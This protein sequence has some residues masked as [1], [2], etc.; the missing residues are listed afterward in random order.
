MQSGFEIP[1]PIP[2]EVEFGDGVLTCMGALISG[3]DSQMVSVDDDGT[4]RTSA[5]DLI[6]VVIEDGSLCVD[7]ETTALEAGDY[8]VNSRGLWRR[9]F[10]P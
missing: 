8:L 2:V 10:A 1:E 9:I 3:E 5:S 7:G 4:V 6:V